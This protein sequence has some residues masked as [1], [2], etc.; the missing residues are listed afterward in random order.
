MELF[1]NALIYILLEALKK[2]YQ[3][4]FTLNKLG[5]I[6]AMFRHFNNSK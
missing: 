3:M 2:P 5:Q 1:A 6:N 4:F